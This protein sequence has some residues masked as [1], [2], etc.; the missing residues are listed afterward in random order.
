M[1]ILRRSVRFLNSFVAQNLVRGIIFVCEFL[2]S[3]FF[4]FFSVNFLLYSCCW[5]FIPPSFVNETHLIQLNS[6]PKSF[7]FEVKKKLKDTS[8]FRVGNGSKPAFDHVW[9]NNHSPAILGQ[10][11]KVFTTMFVPKI[12]CRPPGGEESSSSA[13]DADADASPSGPSAFAAAAETSEYE[14]LQRHQAPPKVH[15]LEQQENRNTM[16]R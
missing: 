14:V 10:G 6:L 3:T 7:H 12:P 11:T 4:S 2:L 1:P 5:F 8:I 16:V 13:A 9:G 15:W